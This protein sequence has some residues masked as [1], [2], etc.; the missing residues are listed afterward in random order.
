[1]S[2]AYAPFETII[3]QPLLWI[4]P[5][6]L[7]DADGDLSKRAIGTGPFILKK[8]QAKQVQYYSDRADQQQ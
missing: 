8:Y 4:V 7:V 2:D 5:K 3:A 6:E 1:M